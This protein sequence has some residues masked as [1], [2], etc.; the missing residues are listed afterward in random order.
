MKLQNTYDVG[1]YCRLSRD[2]NNGNLVSMSITNQKQML[3]DYVK[4][5]GWNLREIYIDDGYSGTNFE[6]PDFKRMIVDAEAR[7]INCIITKDLSRFGRNYVKTGYY[8]EELFVE[9]GI[10]FI[11]VNDSIDTMQDNNDIAP[12]QNILNEWYPKEVSKKVRQVKKSSARQGKFMGSQAPYGYMKSPQDKHQL[13]IDEPA[14]AIIQRIFSE[15][16]GGESA[17]RIAEKFNEEG[18]DS[19]RFYHYTQL[20]RVNPLSKEKNYWN[21]T[22]VNQLMKNQVYIG[23]M[24]QG[25]RQ[26]VSFK[27]KRRSSIDP[28]D[29]IVVENTHEP[30]ISRDI[31][32]RVQKRF[33]TR[34]HHEQHVRRTGE[35]SLFSG[36]L[37]CVDCG[38]KLAYS[39]RKL[40]DSVIGV[41]KCNKYTCN[42]KTACTPHYMQEN[43]LTSFVINDI[44]LH[45]RLATA[46]RERIARDLSKAISQNENA[47]ARQMTIQQREIETRL[48]VIASNIKHLYEDKCTGKLPEDVFQSLLLDYTGEQKELSAK[49]EQNRRALDRQQCTERDIS[50]WLNLIAGYMELTTLDRITVMELIES[51]EIGEGKR[52]NGRR[53]QEISIR[54]RFIGN[55]LDNAK[56]DIA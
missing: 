12:F 44:R 29:W 26:V 33:T 28:E 30:I 6:R 3:T 37:R 7:K 38:T 19:P 50:D 14:A 2:D 13:I 18:L 5:K 32:D 11:A 20:G 9:M 39:D 21:S 34:G 42:G 22:T 24:A 35:L 54:Y 43:V 45:A 8:T 17:R 36:I 10:R 40:K 52:E 23:H 53:E 31:W 25:K 15:Y 46:E 51:I 27:T 41:Y 49:L 56:E 48:A 55:L 16:A 4:E 1:V 47:T